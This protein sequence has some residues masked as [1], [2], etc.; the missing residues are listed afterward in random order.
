[1]RPYLRLTVFVLAGTLLTTACVMQDET[2]EAATAPSLVLDPDEVVLLDEMHFTAPDGGDAI[3]SPGLYRVDRGA[4]DAVRLFPGGG[5]DVIVV[6]AANS[7]HGEPVASPEADLVFGDDPSEG[8][9][10]LLLPGGR[11]R[12]AVGYVYGVRP[13][14]GGV[15]RLA[16]GKVQLQRAASAKAALTVASPRRG[17]RWAPASKHQITWTMNGV[18]ARSVKLALFQGRKLVRSL[19]KKAPNTGKFAWQIPQRLPGNPA[20]PYTV[21]VATIDNAAHDYSDPFTLRKRAT[22]PP[23]KQTAPPTNRKPK[24]PIPRTS[25]LPRRKSGE[26]EQWADRP[27]QVELEGVVHGEMFVIVGPVIDIERVSGFRPGGRPKEEPG[28]TKGRP[29][30][31][32]VEGDALAPMQTYFDTYFSNP[33]QVNRKSGTVII[34]D[35]ARNELYRWN[36]FEMA[37]AK[38]SEPGF[39]GRTRFTLVSEFPSGTSHPGWELGNTDPFG[40]DGAFNPATDHR[41]EIEGITPGMFFPVVEHDTANRKLAFTYDLNEGKG[42][43]P[44]VKSTYEG[45][46]EMKKSLSVIEWVNNQEV[47][48]RNYFGCFPLSYENFTGLEL[49]VKIRAK[50][51]LSCDYFEEG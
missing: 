37:P 18:T 8:H 11:S 24:E 7:S 45:D 39:A 44:W 26:A 15:P 19:A 50:V 38:P 22:K 1:M 31:L 30:V 5:G 43:A 10:V 36:F 48:R 13:R 12:D 40:Q 32:D 47:S 28:F 27:T 21:L 25:P 41:V 17:A 14:A 4:G 6:A 23:A 42:I 46:E 9:V 29:L 20:K 33:E 35:L 34:R 49:D 2:N 3:V 16:P 51:V